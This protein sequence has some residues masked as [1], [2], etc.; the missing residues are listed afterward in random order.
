MRSGIA[1]LGFTPHTVL[2]ETS[3]GFLP[4]ACTTLSFPTAMPLCQCCLACSM[5]MPVR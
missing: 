4:S 3:R 1:H 2:S 5:D